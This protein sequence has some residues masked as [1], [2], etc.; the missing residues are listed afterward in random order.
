MTPQIFR[1]LLT[2]RDAAKALSVSPS[3]LRR[4]VESGRLPPPVRL[5]ERRIA[6]RPEDLDALCEASRTASR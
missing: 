6:F 1:P 2:P 5:S 4:L 3:T